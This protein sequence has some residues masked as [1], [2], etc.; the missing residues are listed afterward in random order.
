[1]PVIGIAKN[2]R[3]FCCRTNACRKIITAD[4]AN[5]ELINA[6]VKLGPTLADKAVLFPCTDMSV[7]QISRNREQLA[8]WYEFA[9]PAPDVVELLVDKIG[10]LEHAQREGLPIPTSFILKNRAD[11]EHAAQNLTFPCILKPPLKT[12]A[13]ESQ[14]KAKVF[15]VR[16]EEHLFE[17][18]DRCSQWVDVL[19]V[20]ELIAGEESDL[21]TCNCYFN[22]DSEPLVMFTS[23]KLRQ[24]PPRTGTGCLAEEA[25]NDTVTHETIR[26]LKSVRYRGLGY[27]ELKRDRRTGKYFIIE[28]NIG[29][30]T[31][32]SA[33][34][35]ASGVELLFA[36]YC[37][38]TGRPLPSENTQKLDGTKW[39]YWRNDVR[40]AF[41]YW[42]KGELTL[43]DWFRSLQ[44]K[45]TCAV[46]SWSDPV[47]FFADVLN[48]KRWLLKTRK[49][50][51]D[52]AIVIN[53]SKPPVE[54][55]T[56][57][58]ESGVAV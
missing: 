10:F 57:P 46:W 52:P 41:Y 38:L 13:W 44:G 1:M 9:L 33:M 37:D 20:Q 18:Y 43:G 2:P 23:R 11:V 35:D 49:R 15:E 4:T 7:L 39:I 19:L 5:D 22:K 40:S 36:K 56:A 48:L 17:L 58:V 50:V 45:K 42:R 6:L 27:V 16:D 30:P 29:R 28:P 25:H 53:R 54:S 31:G 26:L 55:T 24:W 12:S 32:R 21:F 47:P 14:T 34:A 8:T 51:A 3:H